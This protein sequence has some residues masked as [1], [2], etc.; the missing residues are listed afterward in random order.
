[1]PL[2]ARLPQKEQQRIFQPGGGKRRII[3][4]TSKSSTADQVKMRSIGLQAF[5]AKPF[6]SDRI[7]AEVERDPEIE[8]EIKND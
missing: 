8:Q 5:I 6:T 3:F 4:A 7:V 1:M 2:Y